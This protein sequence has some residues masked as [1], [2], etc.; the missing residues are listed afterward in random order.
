[1]R[2][3]ET[4]DIDDRVVAR[5]RDLTVFAGSTSVVGCRQAPV[6]LLHSDL[7]S[8][9]AAGL[10]DA[11]LTLWGLAPVCRS[12]TA[13]ETNLPQVVVHFEDLAVRPV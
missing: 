8:H 2:V 6:P 9:V 5:S 10:P 7:K 13:S 11:L 4:N 12:G 3:G 1:M